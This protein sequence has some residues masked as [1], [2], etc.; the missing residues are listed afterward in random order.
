MPCLQTLCT[1]KSQISLFIEYKTVH[2]F[3]LILD[4]HKSFET[5]RNRINIVNYFLHYISKLIVSSQFD[6]IPLN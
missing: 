2:Y 6:F 4:N 3:V 5:L 1:K